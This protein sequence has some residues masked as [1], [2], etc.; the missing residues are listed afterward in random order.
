VPHA[1]SKRRRRAH[2]TAKRGYGP[3]RSRPTTP[4]RP[5]TPA[6]LTPRTSTPLP[7]LPA[8]TIHLLEQ[9][10]PPF[11]AVAASPTTRPFRL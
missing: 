3:D 5:R 2:Q 1:P 4:H 7:A 6:W 10:R 8:G 9:K 11:A